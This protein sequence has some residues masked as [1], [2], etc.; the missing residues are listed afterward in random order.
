MQTQWISNQSLQ[1]IQVLGR[2]R[3]VKLS[4]GLGTRSLQARRLLSGFV[5]RTCNYGIAHFI[6]VYMSNDSDAVSCKC[7]YFALESG[8]VALLLDR[9]GLK[10]KKASL[11]FTA[12]SDF[13]LCPLYQSSWNWEFAWLE[14]VNCLDTAGQ[15]Q[16]LWVRGGRT[17]LTMYQMKCNIAWSKVRRR[18]NSC[19]LPRWY[20][21]GGILPFQCY[22]GINRCYLVILDSCH[23]SG[24]SAELSPLWSSVLGCA[25]AAIVLPAMALATRESPKPSAACGVNCGAIAH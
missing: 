17:A 12:M 10:S 16:A 4:R 20:T 19:V 5:A 6:C 1:K 23:Q 11:P 18:E 7:F 25:A 15:P 21:L 22:Q 24:Q 8:S 14:E 9:E 2:S 13:K 3:M